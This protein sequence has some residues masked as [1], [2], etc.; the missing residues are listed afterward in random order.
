M[1]LLQSRI[2]NSYVLL[3]EFRL[4]VRI[5]LKHK[6]GTFLIN[7]LIRVVPYFGIWNIFHIAQ[8]YLV[9]KYSDFI[10]YSNVE[11]GNR[12]YFNPIPD[13]LFRGC[14]W[15]GE[16]KRPPSLKSV[17]YNDE[18]WHNYTLRKEDPKIYELCDTPREFCWHQ[19]FFTGNQQILLYQEIQI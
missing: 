5:S 17:T 13:G 16:T 4:L 15:M 10:Y 11:H 3:F 1:K 18:T 6:F 8:A 14:S 2:G 19:H 7:R 12:C 9:R